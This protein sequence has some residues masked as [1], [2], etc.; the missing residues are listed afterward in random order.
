MCKY[1]HKLVTTGATAGQKVM[2][3]TLD[4][5]KVTGVSNSMIPPR[6]TKMSPGKME[7]KKAKSSPM[8]Q[9]AWVDRNTF[10]AVT[11]FTE[12]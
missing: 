10:I 12:V 3:L 4:Q 5:A 11:N 8:L 2:T 6:V 7:L 1:I 9:G